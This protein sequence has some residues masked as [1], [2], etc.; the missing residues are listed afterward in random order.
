MKQLSQQKLNTGGKRADF[1]RNPSSL[2]GIN[3]AM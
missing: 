3:D 1:Y 2:A